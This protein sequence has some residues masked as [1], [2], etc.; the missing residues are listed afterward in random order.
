MKIPTSGK[1][2]G[3]TL[4]VLVM[5]GWT[6]AQADDLPKATQAVLSKLNQKPAVLDGLDRELAVPPDWIWINP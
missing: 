6:L 4:L 3:G 2:F 1:I 5:A